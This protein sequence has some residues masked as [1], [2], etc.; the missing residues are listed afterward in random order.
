VRFWDSSALVPLCVAQPASER[1]QPLL[2]EDPD[3]IVWWGSAVELAS[4]VCRLQREGGLTPEGEELAF[5]ALRI[6]ERSWHEVQPTEVVRR[7]AERLLR[8]HP[9]R[10]GDALQLAAALAWAGDPPEGTIATLDERLAEAARR[11]GLAV[12][13]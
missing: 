10:A 8:V 3:V 1:V 4:A 13:P 12:T 7:R 2:R 11:E 9:L 5:R 6:L